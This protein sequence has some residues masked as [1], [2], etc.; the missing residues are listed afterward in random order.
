MAVNQAPASE[1]C[2]ARDAGS[3]EGNSAWS[4]KKRLRDARRCHPFFPPNSMSASSSARGVAPRASSSQAGGS[5]F[6]RDPTRPNGS[7]RV[8]GSCRARGWHGV[9]HSSTGG[10]RHS[11]S[12]A[13]AAT[14][15]KRGLFHFRAPPC[16]CVLSRAD[17]RAQ[18]GKPMFRQ[19]L[20]AAPHVL[21]RS[22]NFS[23]HVSVARVACR[24]RA[25]RTST[26]GKFHGPRISEPASCQSVGKPCNVQ[27]VTS[28]QGWHGS[29]NSHG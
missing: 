18:G 23:L 26:V 29:A 5:L 11:A 14:V 4:R 10:A 7:L 22:P 12:R 8:G 27:T 3:M 15:A 6:G 9:Q 28:T 13:F 21:R 17:G 2:I 16:L 1:H 25:G 20:V 24:Y 19:P